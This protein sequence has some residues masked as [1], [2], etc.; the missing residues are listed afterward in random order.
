MMNNPN[1][2]NV[3]HNHHCWGTGSDSDDSDNAPPKCTT[4]QDSEADDEENQPEEEVNLNKNKPSAWASIDRDALPHDTD[5]E[6]LLQELEGTFLTTSAEYHDLIDIVC[7]LT[8]EFKAEQLA[9]A[10]N[11]LEQIIEF[12]QVKLKDLHIIRTGFKKNGD[13]ID[14]DGNDEKTRR[15]NKI[16]EIIFHGVHAVRS[17]MKMREAAHQATDPIANDDWGVS[18]FIPFNYNDSNNTEKLVTA[19]LFYFWN[20]R[21]RRSKEACYKPIMTKEGFNSR[22][23]EYVDKVESIMYKM[24][25]DQYGQYQLWKAIMA[26]NAQRTALR[27]VLNCHDCRFPDL[28]KSRYVMSFRNGIYVVYDELGDDLDMSDK[29]YPY[30]TPEFARNASKLVACRHFD[31]DFDESMMTQNWQ[32]IDTPLF[33]SVF[34]YQKVPKEAINAMVKYLIGRLLYDVGKLDDNQL[35]LYI[36]GTAGTG[37][38]TILNNVLGKFYETDDVGVVS[39]NIE[40][41]FGLASLYTNF[42]LIAP[43]VK[44]DFCL[45]QTEW[46]SMISGEKMSLAKKNEATVTLKWKSPLVMAGNTLPSYNDNSGSVSRRIAMIKFEDMVKKSDS[47]LS[48]KLEKEIQRLIVKANRG[49]LEYVKYARETDDSDIWSK[50]PQ[51]FRNARI[52]VAS[53]ANTVLNCLYNEFE[54]HKDGRMKLDEFMAIHAQ[55]VKDHGFEK[56]PFTRELYAQPFQLIGASVEPDRQGSKKLYVYGI[57]LKTPKDTDNA[58][59]GSEAISCN[60]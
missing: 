34:Y 26:G 8:N 58:N 31:E 3:A 18:N 36:L 55:Y 13:I 6:A 11:G 9:Y 23:F 45:N 32:E 5:Y 1:I 48:D 53:Q 29:F 49:Y 24:C 30:N 57:R 25:S 37:K 39:N 41:K 47:S 14:D 43:E 42:L 56:Q 19:M 40:K 28:V 22:A 51:Y 2:P 50:L 38:S 12:Y 52:Q 35:V 44:R 20:N 59:D 33:Y 16:A 27:F 21:Y 7:L 54:K 4:Q 10:P 46:Q 15:I 60:F 17:L